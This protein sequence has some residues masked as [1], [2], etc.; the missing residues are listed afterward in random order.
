MV[1]NTGEI[2]ELNLKTNNTRGKTKT[3]EP[4]LRPK[5]NIPLLTVSNFNFIPERVKDV[6][7][8]VVQEECYTAQS[9][10]FFGGP[11]PT[12]P[13]QVREVSL[14]DE[15]SREDEMIPNPNVLVLGPESQIV[16]MIELSEG[17]KLAHLNMR[18]LRNT[19]HFMQL[20]ELV[21]ANRID[22]FT[23]SET[24]LNH[25]VT[26][27]KLKIDGYKLHR[28]DRLYKKGGGVCAYVR[29]NIKSSVIKELTQISDTSF[30]QLWINLQY[31]KTK[32]LL[33]CVCYRPPDWPLD[34]FENS[35]KPQY[36]HA[37]SMRKPTIIMGDL[38]CNMLNTTSRECKSLTEMTSELNLKQIIESPTRI[39]DIS[40]S[41]IDVILVSSP[42]TV[43]DSGVLNCT[44]NDHLPVYVT[45]KLKLTKPPLT[46]IA[47]RS[48]RNYDPELFAADVAYKSERLLSVKIFDDVLQTTLDS[49]APIKTL[50]VS[51]RP[52]PFVTPEING[53]DGQERSTTRPFS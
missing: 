16:G 36:V 48:Y 21:R 22:V 23:I 33:A 1:H 41:L 44:I 20:K 28:L 12:L 25:T 19:A 6:E 38:T 45:L 39:T 8:V 40:Q 46:H 51:G 27:K 47:V 10:Q 2:L 13:G 52:C 30:H 9:S 3:R 15:I 34:C 24:W 11:S 50:K 49:H 53:T 31:K 32:S 17:L 4:T 26:N 42:N 29:E 35:L 43:R 37:L 5:Y 18:S 7:R 14:N